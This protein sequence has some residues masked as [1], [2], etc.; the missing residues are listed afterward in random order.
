MT[1]SEVMKMTRAWPKDKTIPR[2]LAAAINE[3]KEEDRDKM[4]FLIEGLYVDCN[5]DKDFELIKKY[6]GD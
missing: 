1:L 6:F 4:G 3:A 2:K 5:S